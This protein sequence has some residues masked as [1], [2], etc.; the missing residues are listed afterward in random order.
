MSTD[1]HELLRSAA[2][3]V[4]VPTQETGPLVTRVRRRRRVHA[5]TGSVVALVVAGALAI[6][7]AQL[8]PASHDV[9][10]APA[11][12]APAGVLPTVV[13]GAAPGACGW[14][15]GAAW[16]G[17]W[18][19]DDSDEMFQLAVQSARSAN[20]SDRAIQVE[21][22]V[23][24]RD[25]QIPASMHLAPPTVMLAR[26]GVVVETHTMGPRGLASGPDAHDDSATA[27][28]G[29]G[30][31]LVTC[32]AAP[33]DLPDG[34]YQLWAVQVI[35]GLDGSTS[36]L[37]GGGQDVTLTGGRAASLCGADVS[38]LPSTVPGVDVTAHVYYGTLP[39]ALFDGMENSVG[40]HLAASVSFLRTAAGSLAGN[41]ASTVYL[42]DDSGRIVSDGVDPT[43]AQTVGIQPVGDGE[44]GD[45]ETI[46][47]GATRCADGGQ[48][49]P[50]TYRAFVD[51][52]IDRAG[53]TPGIIHLVA[54]SDPVVVPAS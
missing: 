3:H 52:A 22:T 32:G 41:R 45:G 46:P 11:P 36:T 43:T 2:N 26:D 28:W 44:G 23:L 31:P 8:R 18:T 34:T 16:R 39:D 38:A 53:G 27:L 13:P 48:L 49:L 37:L 21:T 5:A 35:S 12:T 50:G 10:P 17:G 42:A 7:G 9:T 14:K 4:D 25:G 30:L 47:Q 15:V 33:V 20:P 19:V 51:V 40:P 29:L 1:L 6:A 24:S 54:E